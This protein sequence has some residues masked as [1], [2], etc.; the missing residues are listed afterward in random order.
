VTEEKIKLVIK[1]LE[2]VRGE[3]NT[4]EVMNR[5]LTQFPLGSVTSY[6]GKLNIAIKLPMRSS[7]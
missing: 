6:S 7:S 3:M 1:K 4:V 5:R 2:D